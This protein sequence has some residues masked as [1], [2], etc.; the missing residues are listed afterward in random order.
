MP[1][2]TFHHFLKAVNHAK[3]VTPFEGRLLAL[4]PGE[5]T[6]WALFSTLN[7]QVSMEC[8]QIKTWPMTDCVQSLTKLLDY[9]APKFIMHESYRIYDWKT[10]NHSWSGV[11]TIHVIGCLETLCIQRS[12]PWDTQSAGQA[13]NFCTDEKLK[14]WGVYEVGKKHARDAIRH[15][16]LFLLFGQPEKD[17]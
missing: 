6:G 13:K 15:G 4:D 17:S 12:I 10:E 7:G 3:K 8:G 11:P 5:T 2:Q 16:C 9:A 1:N 14:S